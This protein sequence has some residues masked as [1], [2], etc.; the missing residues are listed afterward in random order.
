LDLNRRPPGYQPDRQRKCR[1]EAVYPIWDPEDPPLDALE[2]SF[3]W[4]ATS[5]YAEV[6]R[7]STED[8]LD[9]T[10]QPLPAPGQPGA[11][12]SPTGRLREGSREPV[13]IDP[14][15]ISSYTSASFRGTEGSETC[16]QR[17][18]DPLGCLLGNGA[19]FAI[20]ELLCDG[21][22]RAPREVRHALDLH[23]QTLKEAVDHLNALGLVS[24]IVPP[25]SKPHRVARGV[26]LP[27][28]LRVTRSG[29]EVFQLAVEVA[30]DI[31]SRVR[32]HEETLPAAPV[33]RWL[34]AG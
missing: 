28:E 33:T 13:G 22:P 32:R 1:S 31:R 5:T 15:A 23:P 21:K 14:L 29:Q 18:K 7:S 4:L 11:L 34:P 6:A 26:A 2:R 10:A 30:S 25:G 27:I 8:D 12:L 20:L 9:Q 16:M 17:E 24:L 3:D 19:G